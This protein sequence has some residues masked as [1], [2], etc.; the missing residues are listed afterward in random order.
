MAEWGLRFWV[1]LAVRCD[2]GAEWVFDPESG[3]LA[4]EIRGHRV[5]VKGERAPLLTTFHADIGALQSEYETK[6]Y[7]CLDSGGF[8][9]ER[10]V[11]SRR[12]AGA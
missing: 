1:M 9:G 11:F 5:V 3:E 4:A 10:G 12:A 2:D 7:F 6:G 8:A